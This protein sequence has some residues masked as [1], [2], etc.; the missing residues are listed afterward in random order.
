M[1]KADLTAQRLRE[2]LN[3]NPETG[4]FT[5]AADVLTGRYSKQIAAKKGD[6]A[7]TINHSGHVVI[8]IE[9]RRYRAHHLAWLY[10]RGVWPS[11]NLWHVNGERS[12]NRIANLTEVEPRKTG[13]LTAERLR[14]VFDYDPLTG[15]FTRKQQRTKYG[16]KVA[17]AQWKT[18]R[19][20]G[21]VG[22]G[23]YRLVAV[24]GKAYRGHRLAWLYVHGNWPEKFIDHINGDRV[25]NRIANLREVDNAVN[26]QNVK[27]ARIDSGTGILGVRWEAERGKYSADIRAHGKRYRLG[28]FDTAEEAQ[29]AY[30]AAKRKLHEGCT[31]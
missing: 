31:I 16:T 4:I 25:D 18:D 17:V 21:C 30:L 19:N 23:G 7:G 12:D 22:S 14:E 11:A 3:Y 2:L 9:G 29:D 6:A 26:M 15:V 27:R 5:R 24:D 1:A 8:T 13:E 10:V 20:A 28:R